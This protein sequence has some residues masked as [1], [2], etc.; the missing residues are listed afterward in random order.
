M[1]ENAKK[2]DIYYFWK[3]YIKEKRGEREKKKEKQTEKKGYHDSFI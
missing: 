3:L 1:K 2:L